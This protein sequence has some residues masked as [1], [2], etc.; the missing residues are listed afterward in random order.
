[1]LQLIPAI[2]FFQYIEIWESKGVLIKFLPTYYLAER[3]T[4]VSP[5]LNIIEILWR[6]IK[7]SW[8]PFEAY[9]SYLIWSK[10]KKIFWGKSVISSK[11][12]YRKIPHNLCF[13]TY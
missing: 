8:L 9:A 2:V 13:S 6:F 1:M 12:A 5:E 4:K 11:F 10:K 7:Y 3:R